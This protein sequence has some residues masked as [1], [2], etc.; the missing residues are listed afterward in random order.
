MIGSSSTDLHGRI[1]SDA[2]S[3]DESEQEV[4]HASSQQQ[5]ISSCSESSDSED[6]TLSTSAA[7]VR[8]ET[9]PQQQVTAKQF[10]PRARYAS[11]EGFKRVPVIKQSAKSEESPYSTPRVVEATEQSATKVSDPPLYSVPNKTSRKPIGNQSSSEQPISMATA[12]ARRRRPL[13]AVPSASTNQKV[14][15]APLLYPLSGGGY[16]PANKQLPLIEA[17]YTSLDEIHEK[18]AEEPRRVTLTPNPLYESMEDLNL[19]K[20]E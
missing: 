12:S 15:N 7:R 4:T 14:S 16:L 5:A 11:G 19:S 13:P 3:E 2:S 6:E 20:D 10:K 8:K 9:D 17:T 18:P 1:V